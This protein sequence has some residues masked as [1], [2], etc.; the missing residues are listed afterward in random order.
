MCCLSGAKA[1]ALTEYNSW[2]S[3]NLKNTSYR[4]KKL[5]KIRLFNIIIDK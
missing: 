3:L 5:E 1:A 4:L 2:L